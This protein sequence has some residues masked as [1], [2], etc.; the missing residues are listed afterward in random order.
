MSTRKLTRAVRQLFNQMRKLAKT[1]TKGFVL[2]LLRALL[3]LGR[4]PLLARSGFVLPTTVLLLLVLTLT[5][6]SIGY[7]AY[8]RTNQTIG[9][10][11]QRV[12]FNAATPAIDR[13]KAKLE[14]LFDVQ[15]DPRFPGGIPSENWLLGM[16]YNDGRTIQPG[17]TYVAPFQPN[18]Y[19]PYTLPDETRINIA[20]DGQLDNAWRYEADTNGDGTLDAFV[21][22]SVMFNTPQNFNDLKNASDTALQ[23]RAANL[24]VRHGP[25][26]NAAQANP[27][28][29]VANN[30]TTPPVEQG[31]FR[32]NNNTSVLRKNF[33]VDAYV[34]RKG[35]NGGPDPNGTVSTLEFHQDRQVNRGNKWGAWFRN[36]LEIFP[37]PSFNWNG[38]MHSE[39]NLIVGTPS[40]G[41]FTG[42]LIS[43]P[44]SCLYTKEASEITI[45]DIKADPTRNIPA[46]QAQF[47]NGTIKNNA[48]DGTDTFFHLYNPGQAPTTA[49]APITL[50]SD[51][52]SVN[53]T[54]TPADYALDPVRL[55]TEDVSVSRNIADPA[56]N[57]NANWNTSQFVQK[58]RMRNQ[59]EK[60]PYV[61]DSFRADNRYGPKPRY[62]GE[63]IPGRIGETIANVPELI[64]NDPLPGADTTAVGLD[65]YWERRAVRE[66][67]R[68][69][70]GQR[71]ELGDHS[72]WGGPQRGDQLI[73]EPL[74][75]WEACTPNN[76]AICNEA[77][78]RRTLWDNL[79]SVQAAA[80]YHSANPSGRRN[81]PLACLAS[82]V[83][84]GTPGTLAKS[85]TFENLLYNRNT[86]Q[87]ST[88]PPNT[89]PANTTQVEL[90]KL[91]KA[92][93][94]AINSDYQI[95]GYDS[96]TA[97]P[98]SPTAAAVPP[99]LP[100]GAVLTD[101][102]RGRG[103][104]GWEFEIPSENVF[105]NPAS[106]MMVALRN[107]ATFAGDPLGGA[108]SFTP[109]QDRTVHPYP[110]F[111]MWGDF[112][113][114][115][116]V[117][118]LTEA[119]GYD[120]LSPADQTVLHTSACMVGMLAYNVDYLEK[121]NPDDPDPRFAVDKN[122][123][124]YESTPTDPLPKFLPP[125]A[126][127]N[128]LN[129][130]YYV[131]L[132]GR[133]RA[134]LE[135]LDTSLALPTVATPTAGR[136]PQG[137]PIN[138]LQQSDAA[139][140]LANALNATTIARLRSEFN[141][142]RSTGGAS[143]PEAFVRILEQWRDAR[144]I[145]NARPEEIDKFNQ[146]IYLAQLIITK[147]QVARDRRL[148]F[149]GSGTTA[150][151]IN[152]G[153]PPLGRCALWYATTPGFD[154]TQYNPGANPPRY[155]VV[156]NDNQEPLRVLCSNRPRYPVLYAL[157]PARDNTA[158]LAVTNPVLPTDPNY[159]TSNSD[160]FTTQP[161]DYT[162]AFESHTEEIE[163]SR[164]STDSTDAYIAT[165]NQGSL[166]QP[167][168]P[169]D[170]AL[171]PRPVE[172]W[173]LPTVR[174]ATNNI[175][176][177]NSSTDS[178]I[179]YCTTPCLTATSSYQGP[180]R[181]ALYPSGGD[182][183]VA[184]RHEFI[185]IPFKDSAFYN[186]REL[187][188]VRT[189]DVNL[190]L[191][192]NSVIAADRWLPLSGIIYAYREDA[193]SEPE[194]VRPATGSWNTCRNNTALQGAGCRMNTGSV[195]AYRST[196]PPVSSDNAISPK[197]V[198]YYADP[199]RRPFG[200]RLRQGSDLSRPGDQGR[201]M[202]FISD[203]P[204]YIQGDLNLHQTAGG[205]RLE[206]FT[207][208]LP[209]NFTPA[210]FYGRTTLD[211]SFARANTDLW[212][213][214]EILA[215][216]ITILSTNFCD[217]SIEDTVTSV[218][219]GT[220]SDV[221][222]KYGC[223]NSSNITSYLNQNRPTTAPTGNPY[224]VTWLRSEVVDSLGVDPAVPAR[225]L[226]D[227]NSIFNSYTS[228]IAF[229]GFNNPI[230]MSDAVTA[231]EYSGSYQLTTAI[232]PQIP[233]VAGTRVN[234]IIISGLVPS[235]PLQSYGGLHNFPRFIESW[236]GRE[237]FISGS[238]LQLNFS[239][240]ATAPF[241]QD[242]FEV[243]ATPVIAENIP[244]YGAPTRRWGYD[245][246]LQYAPAGPVAQRFVTSEAK[247]SEFYTE[248]P[249][250]DPYIR[251]LCLAVSNNCP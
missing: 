167:V 18:G 140:D 217:G 160:L 78:Q 116:R 251:R 250:N 101:F 76:S 2:W 46:F 92:P 228:P 31:W 230:G 30:Q 189:M 36:D 25:L 243:G 169:A 8:T 13:A 35:P 90:D 106:P 108:P 171:R 215:D 5:V 51:V 104:N 183:V 17:N 214:T 70:V 130:K 150:N 236:T 143:S 107:L 201:G 220:V 234:A 144:R 209:A 225:S 246:G 193:V 11:Q 158:P 69:I 56:A 173:V 202:S 159:A 103:T 3:V 115:R 41:P 127:P 205:T 126:A 6:G 194:I 28:C 207:Q 45:T 14:F 27:A 166:Y 241:D 32:D 161:Q 120:A 110:G 242:S 1:L 170:V 221:L 98:A 20:G 52:D 233:A 118:Q 235:R 147:E 212:R 239:T 132:R 111:S 117:L 21:V 89:P 105:R 87:S 180:A 206:E 62:G 176:T 119:N 102:F 50:D 24:M 88:Q 137:Y 4:Q 141:Q 168:V 55:Q 26:S 199:D 181:T 73:R 123:I 249:A 142:Y 133:I 23:N 82:T 79:A 197:P 175:D 68:I 75:P 227:A 218:G 65:G 19:D 200:F 162:T 42:Y 163:V 67:A 174:N 164:D 9:E 12:I 112:S 43:A 40:S 128:T 57:R 63:E 198:D 148:G 94:A 121:F 232:K 7:R 64:G 37:G 15:R 224:G 85:A 145:A 211:P 155:P 203:N 154:L 216:A 136:F 10:R 131:G 114:L 129:P 240:S 151:N 191:L 149:F 84:P 22:Y 113:T 245:V 219:T 91:L 152:Y 237:L 190:N 196:D 100:G 186:G 177:P 223:V 248:L 39:G 229:T 226:T 29:Q 53:N 204:V 122:L 187:M 86:V 222:N 139:S 96:Y 47:I 93:G 210:Q 165:T 74:R 247:R 179:K 192:R 182:P 60:A 81:Y 185:Q 134:I 38:A 153:R 83:H 135:V 208:L 77:R 195:S 44:A 244:Y 238:F 213:P 97:P 54:G 33:Q 34:I 16:L 231:V 72:G 156:A 71:L 80:V 58:G 48:F 125:P 146:E 95:R 109:V 138:Y 178:L 172:G 66:G 184:G 99:N 157:F 61:D 59:E 188:S 124:G 49:G